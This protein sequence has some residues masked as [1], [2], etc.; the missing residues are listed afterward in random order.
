VEDMPTSMAIHLDP[1]VACVVIL[2]TKLKVD[3]ASSKS[4]PTIVDPA[5]KPEKK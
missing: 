5:K 2:F 4:T 1:E 3:V